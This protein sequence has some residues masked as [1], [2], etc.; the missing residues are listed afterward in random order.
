MKKI[1]I[2]E[3]IVLFIDNGNLLSDDGELLGLQLDEIT[4]IEPA[5]MFTILTEL[6]IFESK[7]QARKNWKKSGQD[8][9]NGWSEFN[10]SKARTLYI[11]NPSTK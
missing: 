11:W 2:G 1:H 6:G 7:S 10:F 9:P 5:D 8:I 4:I 3:T